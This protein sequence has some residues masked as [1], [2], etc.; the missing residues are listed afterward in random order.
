M[1]KNISLLF[2]LF[3]VVII[4]IL[5][6]SLLVNAVDVSQIPTNSDEVKQVTSDYLKQEWTNILEK[7]QVGKILLFLSDILR[8]LSPVFEVFIGIKYSLS[9]IFFLSLG[10]WISIFFVLYSAV[11]LIFFDKSWTCFFISLIILTIAT[12]FK[13]IQIILGFFTPLF[14][15]K[16]VILTSIIITIILLIIYYLFME[17]LGKKIKTQNKK[18]T[19]KRRENKAKLVEK[20]HDIEIKTTSSDNSLT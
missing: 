12:Q 14:T 11:K 20:L 15:D 1:K 7:S 3:S 10:I 13:V 8:A 6:F 9:W 18:D 2:C 19:E 5:F 16:W 17:F 4:L